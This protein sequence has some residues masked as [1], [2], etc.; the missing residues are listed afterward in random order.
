[1]MEAD[2]KLA[3]DDSTKL[4]VPS[5]DDANHSSNSSHIVDLEKP[6]ELTPTQVRNVHGFKV[7]HLS[8]PGADFSG[9][10]SF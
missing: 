1:M 8:D 6:V 2:H 3:E 9:S 5:Q 10:S 4:A 7:L